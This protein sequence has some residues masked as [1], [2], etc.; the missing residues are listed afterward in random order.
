ML[1]VPVDVGLIKKNAD[2]IL[3]SNAFKDFQAIEYRGHSVFV[4][5]CCPNTTQIHLLSFFCDC[6]TSLLLPYILHPG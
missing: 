2:V 5:I 6:N 4:N 3:L 1:E